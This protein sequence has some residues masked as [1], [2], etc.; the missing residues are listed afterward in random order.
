[1]GP[2]PQLDA[3]I[4]AVPEW[5]GHEPTIT[6]IEAGRTNRNYRVEVGSAT[7]FLRLSH[8]DTALLGID[9]VAEYEAALAAAASGVG[10]EVVAHLPEHGCLITAWVAGEPLAEGDMEQESVLADVARVVS[11]IHA[12]P[13][14][15]ATFD[16]FRIVE[17]YRRVSAERGV[18]IPE[19][20]GPAHAHAERIEAAFARAPVPARPCHNDLLSDNFL[21]GTDGFWLVDYEYSGMGDPFFDLGNLSINNGLSEASQE[22]LLRLMFGE[23]T[24]AHRAR[25]QLMRIM[26]DYREAMWGVIQQGL[27]TLDIDYVAYADR[28]FGRLLRSM[29]DERFERWLEQA[30]EA[31]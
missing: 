26:S 30:A 15:P 28:H 18:P 7:F 19:A 17:A 1:V 14:L 29:A 25:L 23:P 2:D 20:Y 9:R 5:R 21:K 10:P 4:A 31:I 8:E 3:V 24:Q 13:A 11:T 27:S 22:T 12:G 16:V 6:P